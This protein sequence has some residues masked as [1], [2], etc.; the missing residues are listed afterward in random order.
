MTKL[1]PIYEQA[2]MREAEEG[3]QQTVK[4]YRNLGIAD[5]HIAMMFRAVADRIDPPTFIHPEPAQAQ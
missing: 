3:L 5:A 4:I 2:V 1:N